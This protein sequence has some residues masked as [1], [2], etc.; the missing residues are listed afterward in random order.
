MSAIP[1][2]DPDLSP[3]ERARDLLARMTLEE[4]AGMLFQPTTT[5]NPDGT[6]P[7]HDDPVTGEKSLPGFVLGRHI[8]H[9]HLLDGDSA[10]QIAT[11][12]NRVQEVAES[13]RLGIPVTVSSDPRHGVRSSV[14]TGQAMTRLSRWP[15]H[16]GIG[17]IGDPD[18][19]RRYGDTIRREFLA[20]GIR[21]Y[22]GPMADLYSEPRWSRGYGTF[23]EDPEQVARLTAAFIRG[24]RG[25]DEL[26][27]ASVS[28]IVKHFPGGGP[29]RDGFD[30]HDK[31][32]R[33]QVYP[34]GRQQQHLLPFE[35]AFQAGVTQVMPYYGMPIGADGWDE[36]GFAFNRP[37]ITDLLRGRYGFDG[38][39]CTDWFVLDGTVLHGVPFGPNGYGVEQFTPQERVRIALEAGVDQFGGDHGTEHVLALVDAG[40]LTEER[41]DRSVLRLLVEKFRLGLFEQR[42]VDAG[43]AAAIVGSDALRRLG[44]GAQSESLVLLANAG[45]DAAP[46]LP[47]R[48]GIR[49]Y[50]EG[51]G[52]EFA[53]AAAVHA[54]VVDDPADAD[55]VFVHLVAP[56]QP[57]GGPFDG[58]FHSGSLDFAPETVARVA[59]LSRQAPCVV[60]VYLERPAILTPLLPF[61]AAVLGD[62]GAEDAVLV[63]AL[64]GVTPFTGRLPF[65]LPSSMDA[66]EAS[67]EDVPFDTAAPLS[68][69]GDGIRTMTDVLSR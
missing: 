45:A 53:E 49:L 10:E 34:G 6:Y 3:H 2:L 38:I 57:N 25:S 16:T 26:G 40:R 22:L 67:R 11:W 44:R 68:R 48:D 4:K 19:A 55:V 56:W 42:R 24:L 31:R 30:A 28:A 21:L 46:A 66:V 18:I 52:E 50:A 58:D 9:L 39:V 36:V 5:V 1:Y 35:A 12:H 29:Q 60:A 7:E 61:A 54:T 63:D 13:T 33:E 65:D 64:F 32:F 43:A 20:M 8:T 62:F 17:A 69:H 51:V 15:E 41:I 47:L 14:F 23:G 37:V 27:P 59:E